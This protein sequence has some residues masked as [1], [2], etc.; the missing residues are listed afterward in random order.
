MWKEPLFEEVVQSA[1]TE[2]YMSEHEAHQAVAR[3]ALRGLK[4]HYAVQ[5][6][7][8]VGGTLYRCYRVQIEK[9]GEGRCLEESRK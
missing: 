3:L 1:H 5:E 8:T 7:S 4:A 6:S 2:L 9:A